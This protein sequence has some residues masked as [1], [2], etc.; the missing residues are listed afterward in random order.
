MF[1]Q[2]IDPIIFTA[3]PISMRWYGLLFVTGIILAYLVVQYLFKK[4][5]FKIEHLESL[6]IYLFFGLV[7]GARLG[8]VF[9][10]SAEY[11][12]SHPIEILKIWNGGLASHGAAIGL[13][14]AYLIWLKVHKVKFDKYVDTIAVGIPLA[15]GFV[16]L[17]NFFNSEI[18]GTRTNLGIG[19]V[20]QKLGEDF[21]RHPVQLYSALMNFTVFAIMYFSYKKYYKKM[22][23][24]F[25]LFLF[26]ALYFGG[27]FIV[28]F[29]KDLHGPIESLPI[30]MGQF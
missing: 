27:R 19:V 20:F 25:F 12:L 7:I 23:S 28:E 15:A 3:G 21:A 17:G 11:F 13:L 26:V 4:R 6:V 16:R 22:P 9:F 30:S 5:G 18:I 29:W 10:Y 8:H 24:Y 1:T 2:N 14:I